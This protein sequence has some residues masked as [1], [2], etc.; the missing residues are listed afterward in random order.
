MRRL[1]ECTFEELQR[2][3]QLKNVEL[4]FALIFLLKEDKIEQESNNGYICYKLK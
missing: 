2:L 1:P 4:C 3:C